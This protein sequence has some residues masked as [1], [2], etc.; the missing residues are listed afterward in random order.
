MNAT[1]PSVLVVDDDELLKPVLSEVLAQAGCQLLFARSTEEA[2]ALLDQRPVAALVDVHLPVESGDD[3]C[4]WLRQ[5]GEFWPLPV[6]MVTA[7]DRKDLVRRCFV[8][9]A[10][11]FISKPIEPAFLLEKVR[12]ILEGTQSGLLAAPPS[13]KTVGLATRDG[14]FQSVVGRLLEHS[15]VQVRTFDNLQK[16]ADGARSETWDAAVVDLALDDSPSGGALLEARKAPELSNLPLFTVADGVLAA[17]PS[18]YG[19]LAPL[20][21][22]EEVAQLIR[23]LGS[24]LS[25]SRAGVN[26]RKATRVSIFSVVRFRFYGYEAWSSGYGYDVSETGIFVRTLTPVAARQ[27]VDISFRLKDDGPWLNCKGLTIWSNAF[28]PRRMAN[29]PYGMGIAFADFPAADWAH[30]HEFV[31]DRERR[32]S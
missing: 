17:G 9:G 11:D 15:G 2:R 28:G 21:R 3:L 29:F 6:I 32:L 30:V 18:A 10:D 1:G 27:P 26:R 20:D 12:A 23:Q 14:F 31:E 13:A 22:S 19:E 16:W 24:L 8:A 4:R 7:D 5:S 25:G